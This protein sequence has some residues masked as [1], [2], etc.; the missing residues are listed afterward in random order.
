MNFKTYQKLQDL[1]KAKG[2]IYVPL[3]DPDKKSLSEIETLVVSAEKSGADAIFVGSSILVRN[4]FQECLKRIKDSC[5]LPVI[6]FPGLFNYVCEYADA[7]LYLS[8]VSGRN[9][10]LLIGEHVKSAPLLKSI[11]LEPISTAY[12]LVSS[13]VT[14]SV[15]F[16]SN[17]KPIPRNKP[18][19]ALA[20]AL[21]AEF[22]GMKLIYLEAGSGA[23]ESVPEE[24]IRA[25]K[26]VTT[27]PIICGGGIRTPEEAKKKVKAGASIV[28]TG[29]VLEEKG[30]CE[31]L[32]NDFANAIHF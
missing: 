10:D 30:D 1:I 4:S 3:L 16:M 9:P 20:H 12:L 24:M 11:G 27:I 25:V 2:A 22:I 17:T 26:S 18:D 32:M 21:A 19:I 28:V 7:I 5:T 8:L 31:K 23:K 29:T 14:T 13:G 15:E 6:I